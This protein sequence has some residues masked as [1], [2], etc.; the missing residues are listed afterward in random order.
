MFEEIALPCDAQMFCGPR[1]PRF[2]DVLDALG[3]LREGEQRVD[4]VRHEEKELDEPLI[5][6]V[7]EGSALHKA[8][9]RCIGAQLVFA[10]RQAVDGYEVNLGGGIDP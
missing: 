10:A 2:D 6:L 9:G 1:F 5:G 7:A 3:L 4:V 8:G